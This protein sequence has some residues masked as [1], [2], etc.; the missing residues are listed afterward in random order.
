[1]GAGAS[2]SAGEAYIAQ[3][4][5]SQL[6]GSDADKV[7]ESDVA[8]TYTT[9]DDNDEGTPNDDEEDLNVAHE[10]VQMIFDILDQGSNDIDTVIETAHALAN[11][12]HTA[13]LLMS[14]QRDKRSGDTLLHAAVRVGEFDIVNVLLT[15]QFRFDINAQ[16]WKGA[17][18]LHV[19]CMPGSNSAGIAETL[20]SHHAWL[21]SQDA[22]GSTPLIF[23]AATGDCECIRTLLNA[24]ANADVRDVHGYSALDWAHH[25]CHVDAV[26][27]LGG[28]ELNEWVQYFDE[29]SQ[30]PYWYNT[31]TNQS[32]WE[33]P[34]GVELP[35]S[36]VAQEPHSHDASG[37]EGSQSP[38]DVNHAGVK[39]EEKTDKSSPSSLTDRWRRVAW[40][41]GR[42]R[43]ACKIEGPML[44]SSP[45]RRAIFSPAPPR[46]PNRRRMSPSPSPHKPRAPATPVHSK[47]IGSPSANEQGL[48][49]SPAQGARIHFQIENL[50]KMQQQMQE[51]M[52][53]RLGGG[54]GGASPQMAESNGGPNKVNSDVGLAAIEAKRVSELE[55]RLKEKD[56]EI[57][58]LRNS[59]LHGGVDNAGGGGDQGD[60]EE[61]GTSAAAEATLLAARRE[62]E[63]ELEKQRHTAEEAKKKEK[64]AKEAERAAMEK[65]EAMMEELKAKEAAIAAS[66]KELADKEGDKESTRAAL[67]EQAAKLREAQSLAKEH[68]TALTA[69]RRKHSTVQRELVEARKRAIQQAALEKQRLEMERQMKAMAEENLRLKRD[70][71]REH[72]HRRK[73][74][75][76]VETLKGSIRVLCRV[77]PLS[78]SEVERGCMSAVSFPPNKKGSV[79]IKDSK[80]REKYYEY[81]TVFRPEST[82]EQVAAQVMPLVQSSIDG[83]N[84]CI[85]AYGQTGSGK[86]F[87]MTGA[88][89]GTLNK[90]EPELYGLTP[91]SIIE[92]F[93][94]SG[95]SGH[96]DIRFTF[97][98]VE[99][100]RGELIDL[101]AEKPKKGKKK[102]NQKEAQNKENKGSNAIDG[103]VKLVVRKNPVSGN[104][105]IEGVVKK[106]VGTPERLHELIAKGNDA[107]HTA[108]TKM[109]D[110]SSRS[111]LVMTIY[112]ESLNKT[113]G[114]T[115]SGKLNLVDLAGSERQSKTGASGDVFEEAKA[116]NSSLSAL[117]NV[118]GALTSK[119]KHIPYRDSLLTQVLAD[120]LGGN[121]KCLMFVCA[122]PADYNASETVSANEFAQRVRKV[123]N[124]AQKN[125]ENSEIKR[126]KRQLQMLKNK[127]GGRR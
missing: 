108:A 15:E 72:K 53:R 78:K 5:N 28:G 4:E 61:E 67:R 54:A 41:I 81:D 114:Q 20:I 121:A 32:M 99:L 112:C 37:F 25:Y 6:N 44:R 65:V 110:T 38:A 27:E 104:V 63:L 52:R 17:S 64:A 23:A 16:N 12:S 50:M 1:M 125:V 86:T 107:R 82:Q 89:G 39:T 8:S 100:Y 79:V 90:E 47:E 93:R 84:V 7:R 26:K 103:P 120:S 116:I 122:S 21:D 127:N 102:K 119:S 31:K 68:Q 19:S 91:R 83:F 56:D 69:I 62:V 74:L 55:R 76:E 51:E 18:P 30:M 43:I 49:L 126:L 66:Q 36:D 98:M 58:A 105:E 2:S 24:G 35:D 124:K 113:S 9:G 57:E 87:T 109:N 101:L 59:T 42:A 29:K 73:L 111:H 75:N 70:F 117:G 85:F 34:E 13:A 97:S 92:L 14:N 106:E 94:I 118:I 3:D 48:I 80:G 96:H 10:T 33:I 22:E 88:D 46:T 40:R 77:R 60:T 115:T 11:H 95:Q 71:E 45:S 123:T